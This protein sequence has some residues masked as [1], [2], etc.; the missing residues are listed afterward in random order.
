MKKEKRMEYIIENTTVDERLILEREGF[1]WTF[2]GLL[3][4]DVIIEG[5]KSM[6]NSAMRAIG[7]KN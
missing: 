2:D 1:D 4:N 5:D 6:F 3:S 7:R